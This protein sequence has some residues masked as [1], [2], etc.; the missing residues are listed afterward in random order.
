MSDRAFT[1]FTVRGIPIRLHWSL[2]LFVPYVAF[3]A[4]SQ[5]LFIASSLDLPRGALRLPPLVWGVILALGLLVSVVLHELAHCAVAV[6]SGARV[7]SI[8]LMMLGGVS[9][10][11]REL[12]PGREAWMAFAGPLAS[13][14]LALLGYTVYRFA[15][16][17]EETGAAV[18]VFSLTNAVLGAFNL[19]PAY[20]MDGGR[21]LRGLL[22]RGMGPARATRVA[23]TVS[24]VLAAALGLF[25]LLQYNLLLV[26][27]AAFVYMA[28]SAERARLEVRGLLQGMPVSAFMSRR[29]GDVRPDE[30]AGDVARR[31]IADDLPAARVVVEEWGDH[32]PAALHTVGIVTQS[33]LARR[34]VRGWD[35]PVAASMQRDLPRV[36]PDADATSTLDALASGAPA[37]LVVDDGD[38]VIGLVTPHDVQRAVAL[39]SFPASQAGMR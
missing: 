20:P 8:T 24:R 38:G 19:L 1:L 21:I 9:H 11:E 37:V 29:L 2:I 22:A 27:I 4:A 28:A 3:V 25:A 15:P 14:A 35:A 33:D 13:F 26:L 17:A 30:L 16:I 34:A 39:G 31:L 10:V 5:F 7:R 23:T 6:A 12:R 18:L 36:H 32:E